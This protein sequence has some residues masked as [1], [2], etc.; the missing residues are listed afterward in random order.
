MTQPD[1]SDLQ[2]IWEVDGDSVELMERLNLDQRPRLR[3]HAGQGTLWEAQEK[4]M[5]FQLIEDPRHVL[6]PL[7]AF[8]GA[9]IFTQTDIFGNDAPCLVVG[10]AF[11]AEFNQELQD[12]CHEVSVKV[13]M[14]GTADEFSMDREQLLKLVRPDVTLYA[15]MPLTTIKVR[16]AVKMDQ[17]LY[18][19]AEERLPPFFRVPW[20]NSSV[21]VR[22][23]IRERIETK[24]RG[25]R[26]NFTAL[27][28]AW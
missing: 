3:V 27:A 20:N 26:F 16:R 1:P 12:S 25:A 13:A 18:V 22:N 19:P 21:F 5:D 15:V 9:E 8:V 10:P 23:D 7:I 14:Y 17:R 24:M 4:G 11:I 28:F 2:V 6:D